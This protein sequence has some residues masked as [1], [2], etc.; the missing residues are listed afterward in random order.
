MGGES[1][2]KKRRGEGKEREQNSSV[3]GLDVRQEENQPEEDEYAATKLKNKGKQGKRKEGG[4]KRG[5]KEEGERRREW[6]VAF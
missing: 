2:E 4:E 5:R 6:N 1:K 3:T